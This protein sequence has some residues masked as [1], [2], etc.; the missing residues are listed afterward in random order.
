MRTAVSLYIETDDVDDADFPLV[1]GDQV[2]LRA[3]DVGQRERLVAAE[4][5]YVDPAVRGHLGVYQ[6]LESS[7]E[8]AGN[9]GKV[10]VHAS[11]AG[12]HVAAGDEGA[13]VAED[14]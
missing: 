1:G 13:E 6:V 12:L 11:L 10:E 2:R 8:V 9:L 7:L 14:D 5:A 3:D 4:D